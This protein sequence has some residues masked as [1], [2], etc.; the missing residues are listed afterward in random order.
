MAVEQAVEMVISKVVGMVELKVFE[1]VVA[2]A[3]VK[4][5]VLVEK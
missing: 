3:A 1:V 5:L 2:M 4:E